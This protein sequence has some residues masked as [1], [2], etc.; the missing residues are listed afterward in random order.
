MLQLAVSLLENDPLW[1]D[2]G[3]ALA[4]A[5]KASA[6]HLAGCRLV[7][8]D[9]ALAWPDGI[10]AWSRSP[11]YPLGCSVGG[12]VARIPHDSSLGRE[13]VV[14]H[15]RHF[16]RAVVDITSEGSAAGYDSHGISL[17][18]LDLPTGRVELIGAKTS[19]DIDERGYITVAQLLKR[20]PGLELG[21]S[22]VLVAGAQT[23]AATQGDNMYSSANA[24]LHT[25]RMTREVLGDAL[26]PGELAKVRDSN[27]L[28]VGSEGPFHVGHNGDVNSKIRWE[29]YFLEKGFQSDADSD[30]KEIPRLERLLYECLMAD[31]VLGG[32]RCLSWLV[33]DLGARR[34]LPDR[35]T[36]EERG[37]VVERAFPEQRQTLLALASA[38]REAG[39]TLVTIAGALA[40][41]LISFADPT[42]V[43]VYETLTRIPSREDSH[44]P[45]ATLVR[46]PKAGGMVLY[47][48]KDDP[49]MPIKFA[50]SLANL[51]AQIRRYAGERHERVP[52]DYITTGAVVKIREGEVDYHALLDWQIAELGSRPDDP[53]EPALAFFDLLSGERLQPAPVRS[54]I[55]DYR[56]CG[57][58]RS[59]TLKPVGEFAGRSRIE[60]AVVYD[61]V[62]GEILTGPTPIL[63][64]QIKAFPTEEPATCAVDNQYGAEILLSFVTLLRNTRQLFDGR[65]DAMGRIQSELTLEPSAL[66][67]LDP[68]HM[69]RPELEQLLRRVDTV[70]GL[71]EGTSRNVLG[72]AFSAAQ[73]E[74]LN[75]VH[76]SA[77]ESNLARMQSPH[78]DSRALLAFV[79]NSG[80]TKPVVA[81]AEETL[82][83]I[84]AD[85]K[86]GPYVW[87]VTNLVTSELARSAS[88]S[89]GASV[90][91]LPWE[92]AVGS[93][94]AAFTALQNLL[95]M[96]VY[97]HEARGLLRPGR[98]RHL[99]RS[100]AS[101]PAVA[102]ATLAYP[103]AR[104]EVRRLA[105]WIAGNNL[106]IAYV[107]ALEGFDAAEGALKFAEMMQHS[108]VKFYSGAYEQHGQR[109]TYLRA[110]RTNPG[111]LVIL[112]VPNLDT[113]IGSWTAQLIREDRP[114]CG[115]IAVI[116]AQEDAL[117]LRES[118]ADFVIPAPEGTTDTL[119]TDLLTKLLIDNMLTEATIEESNLI[120]GKLAGWGARLL[121]LASAE[122][123]V[124]QDRVEKELLR[125]RREFARMDA[126]AYDSQARVAATLEIERQAVSGTIAELEREDR[127]AE[128]YRGGR[129]LSACA[130]EARQR[131]SDLLHLLTEEDL[132][133]EPEVFDGLLW[134]LVLELSDRN[135]A[136]RV[137]DE[138]FQGNPERARMAVHYQ[139]LAKVVGANPI[140]PDNIAKF[141][142]GWGIA[143]FLLPPGK[144]RSHPGISLERALLDETGGWHAQRRELARLGFSAEDIG[145]LEAFGE[146]VTVGRAVAATPIYLGAERFAFRVE[147]A[148]AQGSQGQQGEPRASGGQ[149]LSVPAESLETLRRER[150]PV[151]VFERSNGCLAV[152]AIATDPFGDPDQSLRVDGTLAAGGRAGGKR[153]AYLDSRQALVDGWLSGLPQPVRFRVAARVG[154]ADFLA[155][156]E[157]E[158]RDRVRELVSRAHMIG[159]LKHLESFEAT[160][161]DLL[162]ATAENL[163]TLR[164]VLTAVRSLRGSA[165]YLVKRAAENGREEHLAI[166]DP[167]SLRGSV[168]GSRSGF[169]DWNRLRGNKKIAASGRRLKMGYGKDGAPIVILPGEDEQGRVVRLLLMHPEIDEALGVPDRIRTLG[170]KYNQILNHASE[171]VEWSDDYLARVPM[172]DLLMLS[173]EEIADE[174]I[175][176]MVRGEARA[177][178]AVRDGK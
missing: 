126:G 8:L 134:D 21:T 13:R 121:D 70:I 147:D 44:L 83:R 50:S 4:A 78:V 49:Q 81:L 96:L 52:V 27:P 109:A 2:A 176:P 34:V 156:S 178:S 136:M 137:A 42:S 90:T 135:L 62:L 170:R 153:S 127:L 57:Q 40:A 98:A 69:T 133:A 175:V 26:R 3:P 128:L 177:A 169:D 107:G 123:P 33:D 88:R 104:D 76:M 158:L 102:R 162:D 142:Q 7:D 155:L 12:G 154:P 45:V 148:A 151:L 36:L 139:G 171:Y 118:G 87:A 23:R 174:R 129:R 79:S 131:V 66:F 20:I 60:R 125:I 11:A 111:T 94:Y 6:C 150:R 117:T 22:L 164:N 124:P 149:E 100:L 24:H 119:F 105:R 159:E 114:R 17:S 82:E 32:D 160:G 165:I 41:R 172:R 47:E 61:T 37:H 51:R 108:R 95:A 18:V 145:R 16:L 141:Q 92:K 116:C 31:R 28:V 63:H 46:G 54:P 84:G 120:A 59:A 71:G 152:T 9:N 157:R 29:R 138:R 140:K 91:N 56:L 80:G 163:E 30:S 101:F 74:G 5:L 161:F 64:K 168:V 146:V 106:D 67:R 19:G 97:L 86:G 39:A 14:E 48:D 112:H 77:L 89:L 130:A 73:L 1:P 55:I 143:S 38:L 58:E 113:T 173:D 103:A 25:E 35:S 75:A 65:F 53:R 43:Y 110:L 72:M 99:Y 132:S 15:N 93:T 167:S 144:R 10:E 85:W 115:K 68:S 122:R 166:R